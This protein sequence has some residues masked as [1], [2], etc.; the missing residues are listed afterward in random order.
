MLPSVERPVSVG[1][2]Q[3]PRGESILGMFEEQQENQCGWTRIRDRRAG[4]KEKSSER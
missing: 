2:V 3:R 4:S 1:T